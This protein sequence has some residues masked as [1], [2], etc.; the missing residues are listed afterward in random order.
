MYPK[1]EGR[2]RCVVIQHVLVHSQRVTGVV[3]CT[4]SLIH[5]Q[6]VAARIGRQRM[7][8][9]TSTV[10][11]EWDRWRGDV[12]LYVTYTQPNT[13]GRGCVVCAHE[14]GT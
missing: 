3:M 12:K 13:E 8:Y 5:T 14:Q 11:P 1:T 4:S 9:H 6:R 10:C 2:G 7:L